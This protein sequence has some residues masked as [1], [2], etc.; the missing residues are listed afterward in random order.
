M[1]NQNIENG[2]QVSMCFNMFNSSTLQWLQKIPMLN[3]G[4]LLGTGMYTMY[5][6]LTEVRDLIGIVIL[7]HLRTDVKNICKENNDFSVVF[8]NF[9]P[10]MT[11]MTCWLL[12][13][14]SEICYKSLQS[15][16]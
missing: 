2:I 1:Q 11:P 16:L 4:Y 13:S 6:K 8:D 3:F 12:L 9:I 7:W 5:E 10:E 14:E 15:F